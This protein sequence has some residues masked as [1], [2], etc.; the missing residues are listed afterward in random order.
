MQIRRFR[1]SAPECLKRIF[2]ECLPAAALPRVR[3]TARLSE[4]QRRIAFSAGGKA[5]A[6]LASGLAMPVSGGTLLRLIR[7]A[8]WPVVPTPRV[9][10]IDDWA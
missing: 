10:G 4:A 3:R 1:C 9:I 7:T 2:A 5:G 6:C 8:P